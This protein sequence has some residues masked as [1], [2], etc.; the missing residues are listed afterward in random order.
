MI[1][2]ALAAWTLLGAGAVLVLGELPWFRRRDLVRR[3]GP[4]ARRAPGTSTSTAAGIT[5]VLVPGLERVGA[6]WSRALGETADLAARLELAGRIAERDTF[7]LRQATHS[8]LALLAALATAALLHPPAAVALALVVGA[9]ALTALRFE[10][11]LAAAGTQRRALLRAELP[12]VVEQLGLLLSAGWSVPAAL[13]RLAARSDGAISSDLRLVCSRIQQ[14]LTA[15]AALDEWAARVG[16]DAVHRLVAVLR[17]NG[18]TGDLGSLVAEE[19]RA[20]RAE[21]HRELLETIERRSQLVWI[22]VTVA[23][24]VPGLLFL[25]VPFVSAMSQV[26]GS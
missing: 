19:A 9:P 13:H 15:N 5:Q 12:V 24:L 2:S 17:L 10:Q 8:V 18:D 14:G 7:R 22:P 3:L 11:R 16:V 26:A 6:R 1:V 20:V 25:A 4:Y 21:A 23:T